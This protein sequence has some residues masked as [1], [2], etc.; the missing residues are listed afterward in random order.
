MTT[1]YC[2]HCRSHHPI[3]QMRQLV[4]KT[5]KRWRCISSIE[6]TKVS[7]T[8]RDAFGKNVTEINRAESAIRA[9]NSVYTQQ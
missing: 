5:G 2:Y 6:A 9:R 3:A 8:I 7:R 1:A 4:T